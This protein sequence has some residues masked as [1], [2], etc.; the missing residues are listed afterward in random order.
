MKNTTKD[1]SQLA[2]KLRAFL[3]EG[4][5]TQ[6]R[7]A[8]GLIF[9]HPPESLGI[10]GKYSVA[11]PEI[12]SKQG[13]ESILYATANSLTE[14]YGFSSLIE[15]LNK[16]ASLTDLSQ[17][18]CLVTRFIDPAT[19][20][21]TM[22]LSALV[23]FASNIES[24]L[25]RGA[26]FKLGSSSNENKMIAK[27]F[28]NEC[29]FLQTAK[30]SFVAKVEIP[31]IILKQADLFDTQALVSTEVCSSLFSA[32]QFLN[33]KILGEVDPF[34]SPE[35]L[36]DAISL[37]DLDLLDSLSKVLVDS[38]MSKIEFSLEIGRQ[39]QTSTTGWLS[40][41]KKLRLKEFV[42]FIRHE[43]QDEDNL[44]ISGAIVELRS[45]DPDSNKNYIRVVSSFQGERTFFSATL[46]NDQ[47]KLAVDAHKNKTQI[48][49]KGNGTRLKTQVRINRVTE[50]TT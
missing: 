7:Q 18:A 34:D 14:I 5:W 45:R 2:E 22:P 20:Q 28:A 10:Q 30:G 37:F 23:S 15:L 48:R 8:R 19:N 49:I 9:F 38:G 1:I 35:V 32:I 33:G 16:S 27:N 31:H 12:P 44:D 50:L 3:E 47:Y 13:M 6:A 4:G 11:I 40:N 29:L 39:L 21:G 43:L 46:S 36:E 17:P 41:E 24:G 42:E 26:K 25:Y